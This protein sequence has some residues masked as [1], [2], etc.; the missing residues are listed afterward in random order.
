MLL[1]KIK[2]FFVFFKFFATLNPN[3]NLS[4]KFDIF[5]IQYWKSLNDFLLFNKKFFLR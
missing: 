3:I 2:E 1:D 5:F 4:K